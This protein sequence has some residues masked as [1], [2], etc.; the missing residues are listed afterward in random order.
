MPRISEEEINRVRS[1]ADIAEVIGK[2]LPLVKR[3][4]NYAAVCPFHNDHDPSLY[5]STDKQIYKCFVCNAGGNVF[6]FVQNYEKVS[7]PEAV[8]KVAELVNEPLSYSRDAFVNE[9]YDAKTQNYFK[10]FNE[11]IDFLSYQ[12]Y[13]EMATEQL[14]YLYQRG[15]SDELIKH[16]KIGYNP[17]KDALYRFLKAKGY[18]EKDLLAIN[19]IR[20][21]PDG[22][23]DSFSRRIIF[24]IFNYDNQPVAFNG[25][26]SYQGQEPKYINTENTEIYVKG[27]QLYNYHEAKSAAK[28][29]QCVYVVEGVTDV[30]AFYKA[31]VK[32]CVATLGTAMSKEQIRL[33]KNLHV[34]II[35]CYDGDAAGQNA[36]LKNAKQLVDNKISCMVVKN[37]TKLDPDEVIRQ[38]GTEFFLKMISEQEVYIQFFMRAYASK[39]DFNNY[40]QKK[41]Y[42][43]RMANEIARLTD[44]FD[45]QTF[46]AELSRMTGFETS[47]LEGLVKEVREPEVKREVEPV[48]KPAPMPKKSGRTSAEYE[49]L[50]QLLNSKQAA[51]YYKEKMGY[52]PD[53]S[54]NDLALSILDYYRKKDKLEI[55]ELL[56]ELSEESQKQLVLY[57]D[58]NELYSKSYNEQA[59]SEAFS[60]LKV[61]LLDESI[62]AIKRQL[63]VTTD[64][65][66]K[67]E[68]MSKMV[69]LKKDRIKILQDMQ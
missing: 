52:L 33:L 48:A 40:T 24:P 18:S 4:R 32:N 17:D 46:F 7:F 54:L 64:E 3:G 60:R 49:V 20:S 12:L 47:Q 67:S 57:L 42:A 14:S 62:T 22:F 59:L 16:F 31:G 19:L 55:A 8:I 27:N 28:E 56:D 37:T 34:P 1:K 69:S 51:S 2:Y 25:R 36:N 58:E 10:I 53:R 11:A 44:E 35:L 6:T 30:Y 68:L 50:S 26:A 43:L 63:V 29:A 23:H 41:E 13:S 45:R 5:I 15:Y 9:K 61:S 65:M 66:K 38:N 21:A 39:V